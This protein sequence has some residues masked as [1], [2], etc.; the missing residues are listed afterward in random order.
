MCPCGREGTASQA[1]AISSTTR[2]RKVLYS[3]LVNSRVQSWF[4]LTLGRDRQQNTL[5]GKLLGL[6]HSLRQQDL[7]HLEKRWLRGPK[8]NTPVPTW[9]IKDRGRVFCHVWQ[10]DETVGVN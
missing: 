1:V 6:K 4:L 8:G 10:D 7:L 2:L 9:V 3:V 5:A